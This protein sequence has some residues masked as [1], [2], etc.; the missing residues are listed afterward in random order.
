VFKHRLALALGRTIQ[1]LDNGMSSAEFSDWIEFYSMH[2]FGSERDNLHAAMLAA[3]ISNSNRAKGK[4]PAEVND[5]MI[6]SQQQRKDNET[7]QFL[8]GLQAIAVKKED[9]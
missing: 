2:P 8:A 1:E 3:L 6:M 5:F 7:Q 9:K 4:P